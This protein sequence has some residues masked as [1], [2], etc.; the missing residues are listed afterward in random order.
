M[1]EARKLAAPG[2]VRSDDQVGRRLGGDEQLL[3]QPAQPGASSSCGTD[4]GA[5]GAVA[6]LARHGVDEGAGPRGP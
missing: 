5:R 6:A 1:A 4:G 2:G 3:A